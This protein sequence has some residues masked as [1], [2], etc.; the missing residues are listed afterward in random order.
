[1]S[2]AW[3][4]GGGDH[5]IW[6]AAI[7][8]FRAAWERRM[9][10]SGEKSVFPFHLRRCIPGIACYSTSRIDACT[11]SDNPSTLT[12]FPGRREPAAILV[13]WILLSWYPVPP[14]YACRRDCRMWLCAWRW[15]CYFESRLRSISALTP[16][17]SASHKRHRGILEFQAESPWRPQRV[18]PPHRC[19]KNFP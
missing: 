10:G 16:H 9:S 3:H 18:F 7:R 17:S 15:S 19:H 11:L 4:L 1:M 2:W 6:Y 14:G 8:S 13:S 5:E 12:A